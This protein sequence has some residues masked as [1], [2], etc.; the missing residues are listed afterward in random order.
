MTTPDKTFAEFEVMTTH[1]TEEHPLRVLVIDDDPITLDILGAVL[2]EAGFEVGI[3]NSPFGSAQIMRR[4]RPDVV[5]VDVEMPALKGDTVIANLRR[6]L[7]PG[8]ACA[9][10]EFILYSGTRASELD[11][12]TKKSGALGSIEKSSDFDAFLAK[13]TLLMHQSPRLSAKLRDHG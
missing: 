11:A 7:A 3:H 8:D 5:L 1:D 13:L 2:T 6:N 9:D 12:L 10:A 4:D